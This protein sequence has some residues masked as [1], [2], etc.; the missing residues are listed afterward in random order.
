MEEKRKK[1]YHGLGFGGKS[2]VLTTPLPTL[3]AMLLSMSKL[4]MDSLLGD[5][6]FVSF[7]CDG[8]SKRLWLFVSLVKLLCCAFDALLSLLVLLTSVI[9]FLINGDLRPTSGEYFSKLSV[10]RDR[11][12]HEATPFNNGEFRSNLIGL[13]SSKI[14]V[15]SSDVKQ[16]LPLWSSRLIVGLSTK[17]SELHSSDVGETSGV[18]VVGVT[19]PGRKNASMPSPM[20]CADI[21]VT[22]GRVGARVFT[23][24]GRPLTKCCSCNDVLGS[25]VIE[26]QFSP[27]S[28]FCEPAELL[29]E[30]GVSNRSGIW[31]T[32]KFSTT[33]CGRTL[34]AN[35]RRFGW[36]CGVAYG[37]NKYRKTII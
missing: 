2:G 18:S 15:V 19:E 33:D 30:F 36:K 11:G 9:C 8:G 4:L 21:S 12:V 10:D 23:R 29:R 32:L 3:L 16:F 35:E 24:F 28:L 27:L 37:S 26:S 13:R 1:N 6:V 7:P 31:P 5:R 25:S 14:G 20:A 22:N 17:L 34:C